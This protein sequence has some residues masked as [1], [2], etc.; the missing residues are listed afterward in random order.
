LTLEP[1]TRVGP[2]QVVAPLGAGGM[3]EVYSPLASSPCNPSSW[4]P[5]GAPTSTR[6]AVFSMRCSSWVGWG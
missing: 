5:M 3:G 2:Y 6:I 1:G 4:T